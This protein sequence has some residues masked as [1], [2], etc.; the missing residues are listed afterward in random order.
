MASPSECCI[1]VS[2]ITHNEELTAEKWKERFEREREKVDKL[3]QLTQSMEEELTKWR[4]GDKVPEEDWVSAAEQLATRHV[5]A[6]STITD[7]ERHEYEERAKLYAQPQLDEK[8]EE[9]FSAIQEMAINL[10]NKKMECAKL[11]TDNGCSILILYDFLHW[12]FQQINLPKIWPTKI[13]K[14]PCSAKS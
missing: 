7:D 8:D 9:F 2:S 10:E 13:W 11:A 1:Q 4:A 5:A 12:F 6:P 3:H 14:W